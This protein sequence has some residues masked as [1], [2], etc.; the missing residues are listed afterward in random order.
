MIELPKR[1]RCAVYTRKSTDE[2]LEQAF[3]SLDAQREACE[4][5]VISQRHEGW[6]CSTERYDDGGVSGGSLD[7][8]ALKRL[9][10]DIAAR[11]ID[12]IVIYKID[13]LTRSLSDFARIVEVLDQ[14]GASFISVTQF[15]NTTTSMGRLTLNVLL[16]FAQF[17]REIGAERVRDKIAA[18]KKKGMWMGGVCP[19]GYDVGNRVLIVNDAEAAIVRNIFELYLKLGSDLLL[20][21]ELQRR[22]VVSKMRTSRAGNATGGRPVTRGALYVLLKNVLYLGRV[23]HRGEIYEGRHEAI[24][25]CALFD[26]VQERLKANHVS[27]GH[28]GGISTQPLLLGL[29]WDEHGRRMKPEFS[30]KR[31]KRYHYYVSRADPTREENPKPIRVPS[32]DLERI[33]IDRLSALLLDRSAIMGL[34]GPGAP[35]RRAEDAFNCAEGSA[36][37]IA[38]GDLTKIRE[39]LRDLVSEVMISETSLTFELCRNSVLGL[40]RDSGPARYR[41]DVPCQLFRRAREVRLTIPGPATVA[42]RDPGLIKLLIRAWEARRSFEEAK[43]RSPREVARNHGMHPDYFAVLLKLGF[44]S[45]AIIRD[46]LD[47]RQPP[48]LTRQKLAR[49]RNLPV[50]WVQQHDLIGR[51]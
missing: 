17:E 35:A 3:N 22:G 11:R 9:L 47:G 26:Q 14:A 27:Q 7:R 2:G 46:I 41:L 18:S 33:V 16:S 13:R 20:Q 28:Q 36:A 40:S 43:G 49:I 5:Y 4:A 25:D 24:L 50:S 10:A 31:G 30:V 44:L 34:L 48:T 51:Q 19:L 6:E 39:V 23:A 15:F 45:P 37:S 1:V 8:P 38:S 21:A 29:V 42:R 12:V 32:R